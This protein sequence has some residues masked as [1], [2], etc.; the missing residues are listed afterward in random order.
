MVKNLPANAGDIEMHVQSLVWEDPVKEGMATN[1][2]ITAWRIPWS[3]EAG[4]LQFIESQRVGQEG[5]DLAHKYTGKEH[6]KK[7]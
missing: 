5:N 6:Y 2:S 1:S 3:A 7:Q 4:G